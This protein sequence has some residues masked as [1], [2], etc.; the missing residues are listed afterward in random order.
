MTYLKLFKNNIDYAIYFF[1]L[2]FSSSSVFL[3]FLDA[4]YSRVF[5]YLASYLSFIFI[6]LYRFSLP[7]RFSVACP[8]GYKWLFGAIFLLGL[9]KLG[10]FYYEYIGSIHYHLDENRNASGLTQKRFGGIHYVVNSDC[11][12]SVMLIF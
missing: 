1:I 7:H 6:F 10:W 8:K 9:S 11:R 5:F 12:D 3:S 2:L 4:S